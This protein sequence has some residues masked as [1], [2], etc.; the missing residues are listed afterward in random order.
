MI[1]IW[2]LFV[3]CYCFQTY[4]TNTDWAYI[5]GWIRV[6]SSTN[7]ADSCICV[8]SLAVY[9][10][11]T[12]FKLKL[13]KVL[14]EGCHNW[15]DRIRGKVLLWKIRNVAASSIFVIENSVEKDAFDKICRNCHF[16]QFI[17]D[18]WLRS[19][20]FT[21]TTLHL[22]LVTCKSQLVVFFIKSWSHRKWKCAVSIFG[23]TRPL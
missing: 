8:L 22:L 7:S 13:I 21:I 11:T 3:D 14:N 12:N 2:W 16:I 19:S 9:L 10:V 4:V 23:D 6:R 1:V 18:L 15:E 20:M 17:I 5:W